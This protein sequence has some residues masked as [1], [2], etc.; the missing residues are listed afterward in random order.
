[1]RLTQQ[2][3][4]FTLAFLTKSVLGCGLLVIMHNTQ[5]ISKNNDFLIRIGKTYGEK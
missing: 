3:D 1:M 2:S 4:I 5:S